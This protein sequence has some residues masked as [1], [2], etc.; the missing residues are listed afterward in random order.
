MDRST[1][2]TLYVAG[3][4]PKSVA[5]IRNLERICKEYL[6]SSYAVKV[7]DLKEN[8]RLAREHNIVAIPTLVRQLPVPIQKIIGDLSDTEKVL[9]HLQLG[10]AA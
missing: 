6:D 9:V 2:L 10:D 5:A 7:I 4:T 1:E 3:Q 8:P